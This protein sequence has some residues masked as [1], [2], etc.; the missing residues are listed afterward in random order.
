[1]RPG[2]SYRST[3]RAKGRAGEANVNH[4]SST[5][6]FLFLPFEAK[7]SALNGP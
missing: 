1:V 6:R 3:R 4:K 2:K 5:M 7:A